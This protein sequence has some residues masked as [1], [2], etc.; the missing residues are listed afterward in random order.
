MELTS[1]TSRRTFWSYLFIFF[2]FSLGILLS[3]LCFGH[4][5]V[6]ITSFAF[7]PEEH[8]GW[9]FHTKSLLYCKHCYCYFLYS[10]MLVHA[11][12]S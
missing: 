4:F 10:W 6:V 7:Q 3:N 12:P 11:T 9:Y 5:L 2:G 8:T 1:S